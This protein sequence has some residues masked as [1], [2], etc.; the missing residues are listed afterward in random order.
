MSEADADKQDTWNH[1]TPVIFSPLFDW[2]PNFKGAF[3]T[4][5]KRWVTLTRNVL[6]LLLAWLVYSRLLPELAAMRTLQPSWVGAVLLRNYLLMTV[7]AGGLHLYLFTYRG[8]GKQLKYDHREQLEKSRKFSFRNQVWDNIFWS[9]VSGTTIWSL[10]EIVYFWGMANGVIHTVTLADHPIVFALWLLAMPVLTS[11]HFYLIHRL[12]HW[13]PLYKAVHRLHHRNIHIGPWSGMSMHPVEHVFYISSVLIHFVIPSH[14]VIF[15]LHIFSRCL[16]PAFSHAG[17]EK[18]IM[19]QT[20]VV[21]AADF[22]HQLH[23]RFFECNYG[24]AEA[25]WDRWFG[26]FHD[27]SDE[28]TAAMRNPR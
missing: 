1:T 21:D 20:K 17:F 4:L 5:T 10:Y 16:G 15:L 6:F 3:L 14:P 24:T 19:G 9:L 25:P 8:Q 22:H 2:P 18:V 12:L 23:H 13:P 7:I 11:S 26:T 28:A 27:G